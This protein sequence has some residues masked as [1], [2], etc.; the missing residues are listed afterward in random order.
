M[1]GGDFQ[2][3]LKLLASYEDYAFED[4]ICVDPSDVA[5]GRPTDTIIAFSELFVR[6]C[7]DRPEVMDEGFDYVVAPFF[8]V[9][10]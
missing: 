2:K 7:V 8:G 1:V 6:P 4:D 10:C 9:L 3:P 5:D